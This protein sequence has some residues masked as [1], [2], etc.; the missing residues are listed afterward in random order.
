MAFISE[1]GGDDEGTLGF[2][3]SSIICNP[4][5]KVVKETVEVVVKMHNAERKCKNT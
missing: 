2:D 5:T 1:G 4:T 3:A